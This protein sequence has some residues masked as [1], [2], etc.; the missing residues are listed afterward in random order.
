MAINLFRRKPKSKAASSPAASSMSQGVSQAATIEKDPESHNEKRALPMLATKI[1]RT[2]KATQL[3][4]INHYVFQL[5]RGA[6]KREFRK[7]IER[8]YD[9]RVKKVR[10]INVMGKK[11]RIKGIPGLRTGYKKAIVTVRE[12]EKID[13][14]V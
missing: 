2:E 9:V 12:G 3:G 8:H 10:M 7:A 13:V 5:D 11:R 6:N 4:M 14:G 1:H